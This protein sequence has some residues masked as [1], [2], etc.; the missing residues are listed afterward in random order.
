MRTDYSREL[1]LRLLPL[2]YGWSRDFRPD[3]D[4]VAA[5]ARYAFVGDP[6]ADALVASIKQAGGTEVRRQFEVALAEGIDAV[7]DASPELR[8][9]F[10]QSEQVPFWLDR[11]QL[12]HA[13]EMIGGIGPSA[14]AMLMVGLSVTYTTPDGNAV[15]LRAGDTRD[16]AGKRATETLDWVSEVTAPG[17]LERGAAGYQASLRVRLTHA[18][19]RSGMGKRPDWDNPHLPV[20]MQVYSNVI[21]AFA[22]YPTIAALICGKHFSRRDR[23]AIFHLWRY[24]GHL[25]GIHP[26][27]IPANENDAIRLVTM[28]LTQVI[29]PDESATLLGK[30][31][32][33]AY[34]EIYGFA[35]D[36][37]R[38]AVG[39]WVVLNSHSALARFTLGP[40][41][42]DLLGYPKVSPVAWPLLT[43][44]AGAAYLTTS[45]DWIP[46]VR[47]ARCR[48]MGRLQRRLLER[49]D[50][51]TGASMRAT[52]ETREA[53]AT[54]VA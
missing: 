16:K 31:L 20:N 14:A 48:T 46:P 22:V 23:E 21:V 53:E 27:L 18:F 17:G 41:L 6:V 10:E 11:A 39:R 26:D 35:G 4:Q 52:L 38:D 30:A 51:N 13:A 25:V 29:R 1:P 49:M 9:F 40:A 8:A 54:A 33:D 12:S 28:F 34:P 44:Y 36:R 37:R 47:R 15:L 7:P 50:R 43:T 19:M 42:S 5:F 32:I 2:L 3:D 45:L 24:V